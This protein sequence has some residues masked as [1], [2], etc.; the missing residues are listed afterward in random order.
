MKKKLSIL[1]AIFII[2]TSVPVYAFEMDDRLEL[3]TVEALVKEREIVLSNLKEELTMKNKEDLYYLFETIINR[4]FDSRIKELEL[5]ENEISTSSNPRRYTFRNGGAVVY[6]E[7]GA[8]IQEL[9]LTRGQSQRV[10]DDFRRQNP[11][12][13]L[14]ITIGGL[15]VPWFGPLIGGFSFLVREINQRSWDNIM[16]KS[17][18]A[19]LLTV[20]HPVEGTHTFVY[21]WTT[22]PYANIYTRGTIESVRYN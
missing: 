4:D 6:S 2:L 10:Y 21:E 8:T 11:Y 14:A 22:Q 20:S 19:R 12:E 16:S 9:F 18:Y 7:M 1:L 3:V 17:G 13:F 15:A 5:G